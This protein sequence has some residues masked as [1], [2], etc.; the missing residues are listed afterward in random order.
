[1]RS[2]PSEQTCCGLVGTGYGC[3]PKYSNGTC[4]ADNIHCCPNGYV[5]DVPNKTCK[6]PGKRAGEEIVFF[7]LIPD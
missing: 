2:C 5:C 1:M 4:C 3:C 6:I 7:L